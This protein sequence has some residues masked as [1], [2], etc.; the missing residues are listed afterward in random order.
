MVCLFYFYLELIVLVLDKELSLLYLFP[1][2]IW[3][4][5]TLLRAL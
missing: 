2:S 4:F 1:R 3:I 5:D